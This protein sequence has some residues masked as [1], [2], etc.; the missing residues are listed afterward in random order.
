MRLDSIAVGVLGAFAA[1]RPPLL[2]HNRAF[3]ETTLIAGV[4]AAITPDRTGILTNRFRNHTPGQS[5]F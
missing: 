2:W 1:Q 4:V 5:P 3:R